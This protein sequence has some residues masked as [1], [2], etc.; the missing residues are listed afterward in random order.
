MQPALPAGGEAT[1]GIAT[2]GVLPPTLQE[3]PALS[4]G[5]ED[6]LPGGAPALPLVQTLEKPP[7]PDGGNVKQVIYY[8]AAITLRQN[9]SQS[10]WRIFFPKKNFPAMEASKREYL[11]QCGTAISTATPEKKANAFASALLHAETVAKEYR[12]NHGENLE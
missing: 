7:M 2:G 1:K 4:D 9:A 10:A 12:K 8:G 3:P 5:G 6:A 11:R